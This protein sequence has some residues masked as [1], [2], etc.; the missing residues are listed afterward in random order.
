MHIR[1]LQ[2]ASV[3]F[4]GKAQAGAKRPV[5]AIPLPLGH[6]VVWSTPSDPRPLA[7]IAHRAGH[8][9]AACAS[10]KCLCGPYDVS[11]PSSSH[12]ALESATDQRR[13]LL[14]GLLYHAACNFIVS[15]LGPQ[16]GAVSGLRKTVLHSCDES[17]WWSFVPDGTHDAN[18]VGSAFGCLGWQ[19]GPGYFQ[20]GQTCAGRP[21]VAKAAGNRRR[22]DEYSTR[23]S[24]QNPEWTRRA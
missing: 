14:V 6:L 8:G 24:H 10:D 1:R 3:E 4:H 2:G 9:R 11:L 12:V 15:P 16:P 20:S 17:H 21:C 18:S 7:F 22:V 13:R 5:P 19:P 23:A